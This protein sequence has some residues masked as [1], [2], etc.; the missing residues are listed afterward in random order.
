ML[1]LEKKTGAREETENRKSYREGQT[2]R[3]S[4][5]EN[6]ETEIEIKKPIYGQADNNKAIGKERLLQKGVFQ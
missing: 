1:N 6:R 3:L 4:E 5:T 2:C